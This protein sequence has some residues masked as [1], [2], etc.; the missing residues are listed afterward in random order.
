MADSSS[1]AVLAAL[2]A[3]LAAG[4]PLGATALRNAVLPERIPAGGLIVLRDGEPGDPD[5]TMS[6]LAYHFEHRAF[7]DLMVEDDCEATRDATFDALR[8]TVG[9]VIVADRTLG[10]R[11]DWVEAAA[12]PTDTI[13]GEP[14]GPVLKGASIPVTLHFTV[15]AD[16]L[17]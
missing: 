13:Q 2:L 6:P 11:C 5:V 14:G 8:R 1:E 15:V 17:S 10:G 9:A 3:S 16:P 12:A 4:A 7:V